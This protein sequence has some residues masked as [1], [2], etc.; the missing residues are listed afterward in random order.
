M[1]DVVHH[2]ERL[3]DYL[4]LIQTNP[5]IVKLTAEWCGPCKRIAPL[6]EELAKKHS[7][8]IC[9]IEVNIDLADKITSHES[10]QGVPLFLFYCYGTKL[11]ELSVSGAK[12]SLL[13]TNLD[14]FLLEIEER[15]KQVVII[16]TSAPNSEMEKL[17]LDDSDSLEYPSEDKLSDSDEYPS[18]DDIVEKLSDS[19]QYPSEDDAQIINSSEDE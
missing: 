6:Y 8:T 17:T 7:D 9:F 3:P 11:E 14:K 5:C 19:D 18:E 10:V 16:T 15:K 4:N 2:V 13:Q 1:T 12:S